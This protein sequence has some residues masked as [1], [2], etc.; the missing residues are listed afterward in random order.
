MSVPTVVATDAHL[1]LQPLGICLWYA[2]GILR[3]LAPAVRPRGLRLG[4]VVGA[5]HD[6]FA[7]A[8]TNGVVPAILDDEAST[9]VLIL[10]KAVN[11]AGDD[12]VEQLKIDN[13]RVQDRWVLVDGRLGEYSVHL[14]SANVHRRPGGAVCI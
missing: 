9:A 3:S 13:V 8:L 2:C 1:A 7:S 4:A 12:V 14:G 6:A 10:A 5:I 11:L